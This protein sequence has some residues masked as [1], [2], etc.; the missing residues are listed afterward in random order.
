MSTV[1]E[2]RTRVTETENVPSSSLTCGF[3]VAVRATGQAG[4]LMSD[5]FTKLVMRRKGRRQGR[6]PGA[7]AS[8]TFSS[9]FQVWRGWVLVPQTSILT[10][11][12]FPLR[13]LRERTWEWAR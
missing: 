10:L 11:C 1:N 4:D 2:K 12:L 5:L 13:H 3:P 9:C 8:C 7:F 6:G